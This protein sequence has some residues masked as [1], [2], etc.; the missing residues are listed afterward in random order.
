VLLSC[1]PFR[2]KILR[3]TALGDLPVELP[4]KVVIGKADGLEVPS[5]MLARADDRMRFVGGPT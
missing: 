2:R 4:S 1:R 5:T 3:G